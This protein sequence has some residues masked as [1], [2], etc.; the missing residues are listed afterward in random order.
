MRRVKPIFLHLG[1]WLLIIL[2]ACDSKEAKKTNFTLDGTVQGAAGDSIFVEIVAAYQSLTDTFLI[3]GARIDENGYFSMKGTIRG[4]GRYQL[5]LGT[6][7]P[8][9]LPITPVPG[10]KIKIMAYKESFLK[11]PGLQGAAWAKTANQYFR[12]ITELDPQKGQESLMAFIANEI[13]TNPTNPFHIVLTEHLTPP[14]E[15]DKLSTWDS[16][17]LNLL[18]LVAASYKTTYGS[19]PAT[20]GLVYK[21]SLSQQIYK[22]FQQKV[23]RNEAIENGTLSAPDFILMS[24]TGEKFRLS[25]HRGKTILLYFWGLEFP[26]GAS[27]NQTLSELQK[28]QNNQVEIV[29][30][31]CDKNVSEWKKALVDYSFTGNWQLSDANGSTNPG[32]VNGRSMLMQQ[33]AIGSLPHSVLINANGKIIA[34]GLSGE[35]LKNRMLSVIN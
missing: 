22:G 3:A 16:Q 30:I 33:Y 20:K 29:T 2:W 23:A 26:N 11:N 34:E 24:I 7:N 10:D 28:K 32:A 19:T 17:N 25:E 35:A 27:D 31:S 12:M 9:I 1:F 21:D 14:S 4:L 6:K 15:M 8:Q 5:R 13:R 18:A